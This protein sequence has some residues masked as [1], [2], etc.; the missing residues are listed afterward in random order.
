MPSLFIRL[1]LLLLITVLAGGR[2]WGV[3]FVWD[4]NPIVNATSTITGQHIL[5]ISPLVPQEAK[6]LSAYVNGFAGVFKALFNQRFKESGPFTVR[7]FPDPA[8]FRVRMQEIYKQAVPDR[9]ACYCP[10]TKETFVSVQS[11][12]AGR[13]QVQ[14]EI[15]IHELSHHMLHAFFGRDDLPI[16]FD[17]GLACYLECWDMAKPM[18]WNIRRIPQT[19]E[20]QYFNYFGREMRGALADN[21]L[22]SARELLRL[23]YQ[24]FHV[25]DPAKE[26]LHY[27]QSWGL[28][29]GLMASNDGKS[30]LGLIVQEYQRGGTPK[31]LDDALQER[32]DTYYRTYIRQ[33]FR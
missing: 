10:V 28:V 18:E 31:P 5:L 33:T 21:R 7:I 4:R 17:E 13:R 2:G 22:L 11:D 6:R 14:T 19:I 16:W 15:L 20:G 29:C 32:L 25:A 27:S 24:G 12:Q 30:L 8:A 26:R 23:D 1:P 3:E 9:G